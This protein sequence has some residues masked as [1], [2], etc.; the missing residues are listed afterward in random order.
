MSIP[1]TARRIK[2]L[3]AVTTCATV[4]ARS[5]TPAAVTVFLCK[6]RKPMK[7]ASTYILKPRTVIRGNIRF[8][9]T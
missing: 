9:S 1:Q 6:E 3:K 2:R 8:S 4:A 5:V 7:P